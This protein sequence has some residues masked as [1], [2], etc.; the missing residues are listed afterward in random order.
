MLLVGFLA[1][2]LIPGIDGLVWTGMMGISGFVALALPMDLAFAIA[3]LLRFVGGICVV[4]Y[5]I[6]NIVWFE[7]WNLLIS[8]LVT[9]AFGV[10]VLRGAEL[11]YAMSTGTVGEIQFGYWLTLIGIVSSLVL[12]VIA[13][14]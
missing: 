3:M 1:P 4:L 7:N 6:V 13:A 2:W 9:A 11:A 5:A 10:G 14:S 12:E 8:T